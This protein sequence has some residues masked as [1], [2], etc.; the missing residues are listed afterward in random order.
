VGGSEYEKGLGSDVL[1]DIFYR[2][3]E[4]PSPRNAQKLIKKKPRKS[5]FWIFGRIFCRNFSTRFFLQNVFC[6]VFELPSL[7]NTRK[8]DKTKKVKIFVEILGKFFDTDFL[9]KVF[10]IFLN[11][12]CYETPKNTILASTVLLQQL[13]PL[14]AVEVLCPEVNLS[15]SHTKNKT[16]I[17]KGGR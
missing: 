12:P 8:C 7:K 6:G 15:S 17:K 13:S 5:R 4:L 3:F 11:P 2:V 1:F 16:K 14:D 10:M 9:P